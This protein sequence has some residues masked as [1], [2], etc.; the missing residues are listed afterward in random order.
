MAAWHATDCPPKETNDVL[1]MSP[2]PCFQSDGMDP[3]ML[4]GTAIPFAL[5]NSFTMVLNST[6]RPDDAAWVVA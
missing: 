6:G 5:M 2:F 1:G 4:F 3:K